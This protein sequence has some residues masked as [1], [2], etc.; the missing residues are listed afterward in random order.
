MEHPR[1]LP[2]PLARAERVQCRSQQCDRDPTGNRA[3]LLPESPRGP[4]VARGGPRA[5]RRA[6]PRAWL[7]LHGRD[8]HHV[9][10][11]CGNPWSCVAG[12][13]WAS[14]VRLGLP[15][16]LDHGRLRPGNGLLSLPH[17]PQARLHHPLR[18][19]RALRWLDHTFATLGLFLPGPHRG[20]LLR[21]RSFALAD[22]RLGPALQ[23]LWRE[24]GDVRQPARSPNQDGPAT[25]IGATARRGT[26]TRPRGNA[27]LA[28]A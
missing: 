6:R 16:H 4:G 28:P 17:L 2:H 15:R 10:G 11:Q 18:S 26:R 7:A 24:P 3:T 13:T 1:I 20:A 8:C 9:G 27:R 14:S 5:H 21:A 12:A 23:S 25:G 22:G 19:L